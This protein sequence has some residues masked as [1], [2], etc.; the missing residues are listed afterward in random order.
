MSRQK[1]KIGRPK[2]KKDSKPRKPRITFEQRSA[3]AKKAAETKRRMAEQQQA[4]KVTAYPRAGD[5]PDF[6]GLLDR[7]DLD[8]KKSAT[9][10][11]TQAGPGDNLLDE[12][13]VA[14]WIAWPFL[15]WAQY[16]KL[17]D[18]K[19]TNE[20]ALSV[21]Q[22]L[23]NILNRHGVGELIPPDLLDGLKI[24]GRVTPIMQQRFD[25]IKAERAKRAGQEVQAKSTGQTG[26]GRSGPVNV[27]T[28]K[29]GDKFREPVKV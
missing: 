9:I 25:L 15:T 14:E 29:Q 27:T 5:N 24:V 23:T 16:N 6:E 2:G 20:E 28:Q 7:M 4:P 11:R 10:S 18:L 3:A 26:Q 8:E 12:K 19:L 22:P 17:A 1:S 21:A 13:D